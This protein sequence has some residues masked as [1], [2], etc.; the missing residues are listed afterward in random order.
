MLTLHISGPYNCGLVHKGKSELEYS[1]PISLLLQLGKTPAWTLP[2]AMSYVRLEKQ[3]ASSARTFTLR[4]DAS[5]SR[6]LRWGKNGNWN[7]VLQ[8]TLN[9]A[10]HF[11]EVKFHFVIPVAT[12]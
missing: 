3:G 4:F 5:D 10:L 8:E 9:P 1:L 7:I 12:G 6:L 11:F 2:V